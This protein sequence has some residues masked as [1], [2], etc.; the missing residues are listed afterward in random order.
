MPN[1]RSRHPAPDFHVSASEMNDGDHFV[2][3]IA[4][5]KIWNMVAHGAR[6]FP[7]SRC[8]QHNNGVVSIGG[9]KFVAVEIDK[10]NRINGTG[11]KRAMCRHGDKKKAR[12]EG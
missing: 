5:T 7:I 9:R 12:R 10:A 2:S 1:E 11:L 4:E 6:L 8:R 3:R